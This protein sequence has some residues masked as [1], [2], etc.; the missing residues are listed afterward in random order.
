MKDEDRVPEGGLPSQQRTR[1]QNAMDS[2][3]TL[4][5]RVQA[6][7]RLPDLPFL[8]TGYSAPQGSLSQPNFGPPFLFLSKSGLSS[9]SANEGPGMES[10]GKTPTSARELLPDGKG[11][12]P[13]DPNFQLI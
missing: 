8:P 11:F 2:N 5:S 3:V 1:S 6:G 9:S 10:R 7:L 4:D 13:Y 12:K